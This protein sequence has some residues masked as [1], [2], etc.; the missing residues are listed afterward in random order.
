M[1]LA[2][3]ARLGAYEV[4]GRLGAGGM[5]EVYRA[6]DTRLDRSVA[7]KVLPAEIAGERAGAGALRARGARGRRPQSPEHLHAA[8]HRPTPG[9]RRDRGR[10]PGAG[11]S[12]GRDAGSAARE[13]PAPARSGAAVCDRDC[14]RTGSRAPRGH[15]APGRQARQHHADEGGC[16][17][18]GLR[19]GEAAC[20]G[21]ADRA[22]AHRRA[23]DDA[24][25]DSARHDSRHG[26]V[27]GA[28]AGGGPRGRCARGHLGVGCGDLRDGD[29]DAAV[30]G[31]HARPAS[32]A[33]S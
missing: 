13:G 12:R 31:R 6:R 24:A 15:R 28:G 29:R 7:I 21:R 1:A 23:R 33:R 8:R 26:A 9:R 32:S 11:A 18:A 19:A 3:G 20:A 27:H 10:L 25:R 30:H 17:A 4:T 16:E 22:I 2:P 14:R 5:G